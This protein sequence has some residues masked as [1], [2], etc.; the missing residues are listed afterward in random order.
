MSIG[1][2]R[3]KLVEVAR[4]L[5]ARQGMDATTMNDIATASGKGRRTLYTY[6]RS[7]E[8]IYYAVIENE[9]ERLSDCLDEVAGMEILPEQKVVQLIYTHLKMIKETVARNGSLRAEF[10]RNIWMVEKVRRAF[11]EEEIAILRRILQE[12]VEN[13]SFKIEHIGL[14]AEI[15]HYTV[16]GLEVPYI[17]DR[18]GDGLKEEETQPMVLEIVRRALGL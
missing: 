17:Y 13:N 1:K 10:F 7:K 2:T 14:M 9:L 8:D 4:E 18:L 3:Q 6:F 12:G 15:I 16:K 5:F 11:D